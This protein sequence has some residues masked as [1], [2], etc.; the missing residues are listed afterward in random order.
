MTNSTPPLKVTLPPLYPKQLE[1]FYPPNNPSASLICIEG[2]VKSGKTYGLINWWLCEIGHWGKV[3]RVFTWAA[4]VYS[5]TRIAYRRVKHGLGPAAYLRAN[6]TAQTLT[7]NNGAILEFRS[8]EHE[9]TLRGSECWALAVD[10][11]SYVKQDAWISLRST[12]SHTRTVSD[13]NGRQAGK[14]VLIGNVHGTRNFFWNLSRQAESGT[15]PAMSYSKLDAYDA[16]KGGILTLEELEASKKT[17]P[18]EDWEQMYLGR[19]RGSTGS[20][21]GD[22]YINAAIEPLSSEPVSA[23]GLDIARTIDWTVLTG[24]SKTGR[25]VYWDRWQ[26][27]SWEE[28]LRRVLAAVGST[29]CPLSVDSTGIG[30]IFHE[31]LERSKIGRLVHGYKFTSLSKTD[32][33]QSLIV[34]IQSE[35]I[36]FPRGIIEDEMHNFGYSLRRTSTQFEAMTG[37]DDA[38]ISL[39]LAWHALEKYGR[40]SDD[41]WGIW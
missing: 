36:K 38:V 15:D 8:T 34:A 11:A 23:W 33:I 29:D 41:S 18:I 20:V 16:V 9:S 14:T 5:Q 27:V 17:M 24:I 31:Q 13:A 6:D 3:G 30:D 37:H 10:E 39:A 12:V 4:P 26:G 40:R 19:P 1:A 25:V 7:L 35:S 22:S 2:S 21:F 32:L 28:T